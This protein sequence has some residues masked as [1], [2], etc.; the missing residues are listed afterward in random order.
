MWLEILIY[1]CFL[2]FIG[3]FVWKV[4]KYIRMPVHLK[5]ELYPNAHGASSET[6]DSPA[7]EM[8]LQE[9]HFL[10]SVFLELKYMMIEIFLFKKI[11]RHNR[12]LWYFTHPFHMGL[13]LLI[14]WAIL[15]FISALMMINGISLAES[16]NGAVKFVYYLTLAVGG[17]GF[18]LG[19]L[20]GIG[21]LLKRLF[22]NKYKPFTS[23]S[24][25]FNLAF[26]LA[27]MI[28]GLVSWLSF[29]VMF[30]NAREFMRDLISFNQNASVN[31]AMYTGLALFTLF[32]VYLPF[33]HMMHLITKYFTHH[34]VLWDN[35]PYKRGS[36][37]EKTLEKQFAQPVSWGAPHTRDSKTWS[38]AVLGT[39]KAKDENSANKSN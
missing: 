16:T 31:P 1:V 20:G 39:Q 18:I 35:A 7:E 38:D 29:D 27:I 10:Q 6:S 5:W 3:A 22:D 33:T 12:G 37:L 14:V 34:K 24:D 9:K 36:R 19:I 23:V 8:K 15:L 4:I 26:I 11:F 13:F 25:I 17:T 28:S 32:L 21:L 30:N 2:L